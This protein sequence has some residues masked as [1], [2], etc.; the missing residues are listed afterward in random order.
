MKLC[1]IPNGNLISSSLA[2]VQLE[3]RIVPGFGIDKDRLN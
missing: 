1:H 3:K 2:T